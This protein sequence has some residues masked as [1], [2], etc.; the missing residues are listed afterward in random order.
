MIFDCDTHMSPYRNFEGAVNA[1]QLN[2]M[3]ARGGVDQALVWLLPQEVEDVSESNLYIYENAKKYPRLAVPFG[4]ANVMEGEQKALQDAR[5][6]LLEYGF[7]G[8]KLNGAQN[9]YYIDSPS[10][11]R[12]CEEIAKNGGVI[13]FHIGADEPDFTNASRAAAVAKAFPE[14]PIMMVHMGGAGS[15]D[16]SSEVIAAAK[17]CP[18][19][20][21]IGSAIGAASVK[22]A[23]DELG[24]ERVM[25][26][27]DSP[28][29]DPRACAAA[30]DEML[31]PYDQAVKDLVMYQ[32]AQR[33][34][35]LA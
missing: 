8:V 12:V 29:A 9:A 34:F 3:L 14:T 30:Y 4:W 31:R 23:I 16:R 15:P 27:S 6:C 22:T 25:F 18:N 20:W 17:E 33:L 13:A 10:A 26:G 21:L 35:K 1:E 5:T 32:N 7:K 2:D 11:M 19:M 24:A 28:F